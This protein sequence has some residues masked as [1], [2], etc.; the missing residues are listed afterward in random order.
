MVFLCGRRGDSG[1][2]KCLREVCGRS[3]FGDE[4]GL[5]YRLGF[6]GRLDDLERFEGRFI[7]MKVWAREIKKA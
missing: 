5:G 4:D 3:S 6:G 1:Q 7:F 2:R